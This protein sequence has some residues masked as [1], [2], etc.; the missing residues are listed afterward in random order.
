MTT[1][2]VYEPW[3]PPDVADPLRLA[4]VGMHIANGELKIQFHEVVGA[5]RN[6]V[7]TFPVLPVLFKMVNESYRL[8]S[9]KRLPKQRDGSLYIV[10]NSELLASFHKD[11]M[12][13]YAADP[14]VHFAVITDEWID[15]VLTALPK[16]QC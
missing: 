13:I 16:V 12:G 3:T 9:L 5:R 10:K 1:E 4:F 15:M 2:E 6:V 14:L 11:A 7:L 8:N